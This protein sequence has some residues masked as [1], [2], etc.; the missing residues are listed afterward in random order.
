MNIEYPMETNRNITPSK[1][2][3]TY[4]LHQGGYLINPGEVINTSIPDAHGFDSHMIQVAKAPNPLVGPF[5][6]KGAQPGDTLLVNIHSLTPNRESGF[7]CKDIH[8][9]LHNPPLPLSERRREY[10]TWQID[11]SGKK[12]HLLGEY[13]PNPDF[14]LLVS[15]ILGCIGVAFNR[16]G[17]ISSADCGNYGGNMDYPRIKAGTSVYLPVFIENAYLFLGDGHALQGA[18]EIN[19]NGIETSFDLSFSVQIGKMGLHYPAGEDAEFIYT[20]GIA[21]SLAQ[22]VRIATEEMERWLI[23]H[24]S[25]NQDQAGILMGQVVNFEIG[26]MVSNAYSVGCCFPKFALQV[27]T[28]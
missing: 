10:V 1:F 3:L 24:F 16:H 20:I 25:L 28:S 18:G 23:N 12:T 9:N 6:V 21:R 26:N 17:F 8:P 5:L 11:V 13:F 19:G 4:G 22:A 2:Q 14:Y 15:P 27:M 7:S